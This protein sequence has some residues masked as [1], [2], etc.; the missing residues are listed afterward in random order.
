MT[1]LTPKTK[2]S[3]V[4]FAPFARVLLC[5]GFLALNL[6][7][8]APGQ[9]SPSPARSA[10]RGSITGVATDQTG[11]VLPGATVTVRDSAG[12][13]WTATANDQGQYVVKGLPAGTYSVTVSVPKFQDFHTDGLALTVGQSVPID[14]VLEPAIETTS[15]N[16]EGQKVSQVETE[17]SQIVGNITQRE[18]VTLGLNGRNFTQLIALTPGVSNQTGQDEAKVGVLGSVRY[19]VNGGRVEYNSFNVDGGDV[20][21]V[22]LNGNQS[23]LIVY[24]SLDA[25]SSV[26][27]LTSNY[28]AMYGRTA[29]GTVLA[30]S[31]SGTSRFHGNA[32]EFLR[33]EMFNAR[34]YFDRPNR[35]PLYR[36]NDFGFTLGGPLFIPGL[37]NPSKDKTY[38]FFSEEWRLERTP[39]PYNQAVPSVAERVGNFSDVCP[40]ATAGIDGLP[41]DQSKFTR[42]KFPDCPGIPTNNF[43]IDPV[44]GQRTRIYQTYPGNV[45]PIDPNAAA[46]M[47]NNIIPLPNATEGCN[48]S[49]G[50]CFVTDV[51]PS[52]YWRE[53]LLKIDHNLTSSMKLS[54]RYIHDSW[55]TTILTPQWGSVQNN[56]PTVQSAFTGPGLSM[57]V[58]LTNTISPTLLNEFVFSYTTDHIT[59]QNIDSNG[60]RWE[61]PAGLTMGYL[62][63]NGFGGKMPGIVIGGTNKAYGGNGFAVDPGYLPW[64]HANPTYNFRD[65]IS[66]VIGKHTLQMGVQWVIAQRNELNQA[67]GA[68]TGDLQGILGFSNISSSFSIGNAFADFLVGPGS[69]RPNASGGV[70]YF[71]QDS[72]QH[73]YFNRYNVVEPYFQDD[74][75]VNNRLTLNLGLRISLFGLWHEK[76]NNVYNWVPSAFSQA[77]AARTTIDTFTGGLAEPGTCDGSGTLCTPIPLNPANL[78]PRI[79]NGLVRCGVNGVPDGCMA[80]HL[81]NPAPRIGFAFDPHGDGKTSIRAGYG[82]FFHHGTGNE[83]NTGSLEG[84]A[85]LVLDMTQNRPFSYDC[86]GGVGQLPGGNGPCRGSGAYP[87]NVTAV[88]TKAI[89]PYVQQWSFSVQRQINK[90]TVAT[91]AYVG[92]KGTHLTTDLQVNQLAPVPPGQNPFQPGQAITIE[93]C[94]SYDTQSFTLFPN[95]GTIITPGQQFPKVT[96][97][98]PGFINLQAACF[99]TPGTGVPD[100]NF[101]R[102]FAPGL[103]RVFS[104]QNVADSSYHSMQVT[105]RHATGPFTLGVSYSYSHSIDDSSD[106]SDT[107]LVNSFDLASNKASSNF[108]Q[109]HLLNISY[110]YKLDHFMDRVRRWAYNVGSADSLPDVTSRFGHAFLIGWELSGITTF[111]SGTPFSVINGGSSDGTISV[112]D[113]AGVANGVGAGSYPDVIGDPHASPRGGSRNSK[114]IG[115]AIGNSAAFAAPTGLTFGN[116][117][118][119]FLNNPSRLNWD[120]SLLKHFKVT[121]GSSVEFRTEFFNVFNHTQFIV[122]DPDRGNQANNT[123][124]CYGGVNNSAGDPSC[125]TGSSFLHPIAAHRPRTVQFGLKYS[126]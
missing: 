79:T 123:I 3:L 80:G 98:Q 117:G 126:F 14:A 84:S 97:G 94:D 75:R 2:G 73:N 113:N 87:L 15:V 116:A 23:T 81:F 76:Y 56:F 10:E 48:S 54:F 111:Q 9:T 99:G 95:P 20:L 43:S 119:N 21:N 65:D 72:A 16:V 100:P 55:N 59:L 89:W 58:H 90:T 85:P 71:Q 12:Q 38:F 107:T 105:L 11:A 101:L 70:K 36:R 46:L 60:A 77:L 122:Y 121:E 49:V 69:F 24:P 92:S 109:R 51:S 66:K 64:H 4:P 125:L 82:V 114:S 106:R 110:L 104:L 68:N 112:L 34:N 47:S 50:S 28:G 57:L 26:Q 78:D 44:T 25:L 1:P 31:K 52:T 74:W 108:D 53:E 13:N 63:N 61:R 37:Y 42:T 22:G 39:T 27:V 35:T 32:Y 17:T 45:I 8:A 103:G 86:I 118:R 120:V 62:F 29:S 67:V 18:L 124:N 33:N 30:E 5:L 19:S 40:F 83:A 7:A 88:P 41:G 102:T 115:P 93:T 6:S 91:I 96:P